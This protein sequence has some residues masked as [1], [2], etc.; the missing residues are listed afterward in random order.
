MIEEWKRKFLKIAA[1]GNRGL[2]APAPMRAQLIELVQNL[3]GSYR[4]PRNA[5]ER[6]AMM[7]GSWSVIF[8]T[9]PDLV[10]L[11]RLPLPLWRTARIGQMFGDEGEA[12]NEIEFVSPFGTRINQTVQCDWKLTEPLSKDLRVELTFRGAST[13]LASLA[14][15]DLPVAPPP[16]SVPLPP[17]TGVFKVSFLDDEFLVQRTSAGGLGVNVLVRDGL[18]PVG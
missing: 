12:E 2:G 14:G 17:G 4:A 8:T 10:S 9:S 5:T 11:D 13:K 18:R 1:A 3:E 6:Q 15:F 16:L 7:K